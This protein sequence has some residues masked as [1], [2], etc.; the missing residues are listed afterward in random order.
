MTV[1]TFTTLKKK[2]ISFGLD[3]FDKVT[4]GGVLIRLSISLLLVL[5][6]ES[7]FVCV[8][9]LAPSYFKGRTCYTS[10]L[11]WQR[12]ELLKALMNLLNTP[13]KDITE[14]PKPMFETKFRVYKRKHRVS[15]SSKNIQQLHLSH[16]GHF[17]SLLKELAIK[18]DFYP[19]IIFIDYLNI[20]CLQ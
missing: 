15:Y 13:I 12:R 10:H 6:S 4:K 16:S 2:S 17:E 14:I 11:R 7:L 8:H 5:G 3:Y 9:L 18:K 19:D 20:C 1:M